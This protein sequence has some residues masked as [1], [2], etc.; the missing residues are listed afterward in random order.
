MT[1]KHTQHGFVEMMLLG[2]IEPDW[3]L[4]ASELHISSTAPHMAKN[5]QQYKLIQI[6]SSSETLTLFSIECT[7]V[8]IYMEDRL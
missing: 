1:Q 3:Y 5:G 7:L 4:C 2:A 8:S 6:R